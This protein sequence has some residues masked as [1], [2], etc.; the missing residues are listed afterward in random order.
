MLRLIQ[1]TVF[2]IAP[3]LQKYVRDSLQEIARMHTSGPHRN[4]FE[5]KPEFKTSGRGSGE[6]TGASPT[7]SNGS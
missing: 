3:P 5:L 4:H 2:S 1:C 7:A 6:G